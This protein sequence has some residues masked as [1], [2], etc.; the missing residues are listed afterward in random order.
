M[1]TLIAR[2][3]ISKY[4][5]DAQNNK[6]KDC[7]NVNKLGDLGNKIYSIYCNNV[8]IIFLKDARVHPVK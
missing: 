8:I 7:L 1:G 2:K 3:I 6:R 4:K 5:I